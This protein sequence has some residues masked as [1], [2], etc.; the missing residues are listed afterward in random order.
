MRNYVI[1]DTTTVV[2]RVHVNYVCSYWMCS[3]AGL[4]QIFV[5]FVGIVNIKWNWFILFF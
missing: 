4:L 3:N 5:C 2:K 1:V